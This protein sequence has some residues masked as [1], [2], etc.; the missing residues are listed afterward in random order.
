MR[1]RPVLHL[2]ALTAL[3]A[4]A[5]ACAPKPPPTPI[6]ILPGE[7]DANVARP[8]APRQPAAVDPWAGRADL[9]APP[10]VAAPAPVELPQIEEFELPNG[11]KAF[12]VRS[13]RLP[14]VSLQLAIRA[15]RMHEPKSR[16]GVAELTADML[17]KGTARRDAA[18]LAKAI[19]FVGGTIAVDATFEATLLSC[20]V[21]RKSVGT[22][23][24]LV[25][26]MLTQPTF[27]EAE[28]VKARDQVRGQIRGR[29]DDPAAIASQHV[30][31][32]LWGSEHVRGWVPSEAAIDGLRREDLVAWHKTW[33]VPNNALLVIAG[34]V[35]PARVKADLQRA[36]GG[37]KR[38]PV[39]PAPSYK[40]PGLSGSRIRLV[41]RPGLAQ[42]HIRIAELGIKHEDPRFFDT[43]VWNAALGGGPGSR[44][45]RSAR[46]EA[47]RFAAS[48]SFDRNLDRGSLV[49]Q[50]VARADQAVATTKLLL[51]EVAK[52]AKDGPTQEEVVAAVASIAG[53]YG[54][55][56][57]AASDVG[58]ALIGA[59]L[60]GFGREYLANFPIAVGR[61]DAASAKQA[62][63]EILDPRS[64][65]L[66]LVGDAK[67]LEP[68]LKK[69]GW[70]Y[71]KVSFTDAITAP[72]APEAAP[73]APIDPKQAEA[74]KK[75]VEEALA[76][77]GGKARLA[78]LKGFRMVATGTT[79]T[80]RGGS[81]PVE[82]ERV[83][84]FPDKMRIDATLDGKVKVTI[85]VA[86][87]TGW[88]VAPDPSGQ[89]QALIE[90]TPEEMAQLELERWR[91]PELILLKALEPGAKVYL[92]PDEAIDGKPHAVVKLR[93]PFAGLEVAMYI[94]RKTKLVSK[95]TYTEGR[96][97][98]T[99][100]LGDYRTV[101]GVKIAYKRHSTGGRE[102]TIELKTVE[103]DPKVDP[104][105][106]D[107]PAG[108]P[109]A[110]APA[111]PPAGAAPKAD[112]KAAPAA[113]APA[114]PKPAAAAPAPAAPKPAAAAPAPAA[115]KPAAPAAEPKK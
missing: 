112:Q 103:L 70:R 52:M 28:L 82:I 30:Q 12:V 76:A 110:S 23:L 40:E 49:V 64:Y 39:P 10:A 51:G 8:P 27:P 37:W 107:K 74:A 53:G 72:T 96:T 83:F 57:Q 71:Q 87:K 99:D 17:V 60:H 4:L 14:V 43:L 91:E 88:Q 32:L 26:E 24:E 111:A 67:D 92:A 69:E 61:V 50:A 78:A 84:V 6:P 33:F 13:E 36:F 3:G 100:E 109:A 62:A 98:Q 19:D 21:L 1:R 94:D 55:R 104:K 65:V 54:L 22:C 56:F 108:V 93:T 47:G 101:G 77:K 34:D 97:S 48:S 45:A 89:G 85:A 9:I 46:P 18:A 16:L 79:A 38:G 105:L 7:G 66:V 25:P 29:F 68:Q 44:L 102:T 80:P 90:F 58:A 35:D 75:I 114:A 59:E 2:A 106:F 42:A 115:P 73:E 95:M 113:P 5:A 86:G 41:D 11:L 63:A 81:V 31:N 20:S 15:G